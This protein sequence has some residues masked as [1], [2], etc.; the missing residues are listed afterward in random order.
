MSGS[1]GGRKRGRPTVL[2]SEQRRE[3]ARL[4]Q[5]RRRRQV[6][7]EQFARLTNSARRIELEV[8]HWLDLL[9]FL[10]TIELLDPRNVENTPKIE[11]AV[12]K[13]LDRHLSDLR[14]YREEVG[15][16]NEYFYRMRMPQG[17]NF[18]PSSSGPGTVGFWLDL[19]VASAL[20]TDIEDTPEIKAHLEDVLFKFYSAIEDWRRPDAYGIPFGNVSYGRGL[21]AF[22]TTPRRTPAFGC[23]VNDALQ[24]YMGR[25][26]GGSEQPREM[27]LLKSEPTWSDAEVEALKRSAIRISKTTLHLSRKEAREVREREDAR[28]RAE[29]RERAARR[30]P[31]KD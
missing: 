22:K 23:E 14:D 19:D 3:R 8:L 31:R 4:R 30:R 6:A 20:D 15:L 28:A 25:G 16:P 5:A 1:G 13:L 2:T 29:I 18:R 17:P 26:G 24:A 27:R 7:N 10:V 12:G 9:D 11:D 21:E